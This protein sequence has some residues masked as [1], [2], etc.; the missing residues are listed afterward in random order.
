VNN[1]DTP[2]QTP[3]LKPGIVPLHALLAPAERQ[4]LAANNENPE[5]YTIIEMGAGQIS[6]GNLDNGQYALSI[7]IPIPQGVFK[8]PNTRLLD[9]QGQAA[10]PFNNVFAAPPKTRF[11]VRADRLTDKVR[12]QMFASLAA[13]LRPNTSAPGGS[14]NE[15]DEDAIGLI[16]PDP[17]SNG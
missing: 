4:L 2:Q 7:V 16:H 9:A 6:V 13:Q 11:V 17:E 14:D 15:V 10:N 12:Q 1:E 3:A 5:E 8:L